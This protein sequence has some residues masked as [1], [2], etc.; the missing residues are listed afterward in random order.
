MPLTIYDSE[1][2][3]HCRATIVFKLFKSEYVELTQKLFLF[4]EFFAISVI[5]FHIVREYK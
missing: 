4:Q 1:G 3:L 5:Y 2:K